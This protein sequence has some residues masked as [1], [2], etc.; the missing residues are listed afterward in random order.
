MFTHKD[1]QIN[2]PKQLYNRLEFKEH[3][4]VT[5]SEYLSLPFPGTPKMMEFNNIWTGR[6]TLSQ[7]G[8]LST[9][10]WFVQD[11]D[12]KRTSTTG[13]GN[14]KRMLE[15]KETQKFDLEIVGEEETSLT[16]LRMKQISKE[17]ILE[18]VAYAAG[19]WIFL[20]YSIGY[21]VQKAV[22]NEEIST[23]VESAQEYNKVNETEAEEELEKALDDIL[24]EEQ[25]EFIKSQ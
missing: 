6:F 23:E 17:D 8:Y 2:K 18:L 25:K 22:V 13:G 15:Q 11:Q 20:S 19:L 9:E 1:A 16:G 5:S 3:K 7:T 14:N 24:T 4:I 21:M 10:V 12:E